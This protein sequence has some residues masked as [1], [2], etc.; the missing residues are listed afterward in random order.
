MI[1]MKFGGTSV[2]NAAAFR[3]VADIVAARREKV[4]IVVV[5]ATGKTTD[6]L[7]TLCLHASAGDQDEAKGLIDWII[8]KH[9]KIVQDLG[10]REDEL[11]S[12]VLAEAKKRLQ[13]CCRAMMETGQAPAADRDAL[14]GIGEFLSSRIL[15]RFL[16]SEKIPSQWVDARQ[17]MMT[18]S[19]FGRARP[20]V[21]E[22]K[23]RI[24]P[25][26]TP[27]ISKGIVAVMQGFVGSDLEGHSTTLGR[28][29]SDYS[30]TLVAALTEAEAVEIWTDVDGVMTADPTLVPEARRIRRMTFQEASELAYFGAKVLHPATILPAV[31]KGIPVYVLNSRRPREGGTEILPALNPL[32]F[33]RGDYRRWPVKSIAYK[34]GLS[35]I[36]I[37]STRMLMAYGFLAG[38]FEIFARYRTSVDLVST[39]EVSVSVTIDNPEHLPQILKELSEFAEVEVL[40][41]KAIVCVVGENIGRI[42]GTAARIFG[43]LD[44]F[45]IHLISQGASDVNISFVIDEEDIPAVVRRLHERIFAGELDTD[46][47]ALPVGA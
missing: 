47:F 25:L 30:A 45:R 27:L 29:G 10:L 40:E 17:F 5:S 1:V 39:S 23:K 22:S 33:P 16:E 28:G 20:L 32:P 35:V 37:K 34:E 6:E 31:E 21:A 38:I 43:T 36:M 9:Q 8:K 18:D 12:Q 46:I 11:L 14:L 44:D 19:S 3:R 7:V 26:I 41:R 24:D 4:P 13:D 2:E 42:P 15:A